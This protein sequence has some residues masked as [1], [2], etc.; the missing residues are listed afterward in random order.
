MSTDGTCSVE[1]C[2]RLR[3]SKGFC[4]SHYW[5]HRHGVPLDGPFRQFR[6]GCDV[7]GCGR[8]HTAFGFC[9]LHYQRVRT[10]KPLDQPIRVIAPGRSC[11]V[12]GCLR[13]HA[14][15][16]FC[17]LHRSQQLARDPDRLCSVDAC[18]R[19]RRSRG[20]CATHA[21][22]Q[23]AGKPLDTPIRLRGKPGEGSIHKH[24]YRIHR[25]DGRYIAEHRLVMEQYL[26]R[27]LLPGETVHHR[28]G[29]RS[30]NDISNLELW[31]S[32]QPSGQRVEDKVAWALEI[33]ALY[34]PMFQQPLPEV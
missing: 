12:D 7:A 17:S 34:G 4:G 15:K 31:S 22:R 19:P 8:K 6:V 24:G 18:G 14:A 16:G 2:E 26:G 33:L 27:R 25:R 23:L 1:G 5:R 13:A 28:D 11:S 20:M 30:F 10:G 21:R 32:S 9:D 29:R 3:K